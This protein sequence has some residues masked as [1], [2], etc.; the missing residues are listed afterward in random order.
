MSERRF[1]VLI[2][3][4]EEKIGCVFLV[5]FSL[6]VVGY[7]YRT[8]AQHLPSQL[9]GKPEEKEQDSQEVPSDDALCW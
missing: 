1:P 4:D 2:L 3:G 6:Y 7:H 9:S 5:T 8:P